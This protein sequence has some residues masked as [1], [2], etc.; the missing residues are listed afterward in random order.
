MGFSHVC[1]DQ[2]YSRVDTPQSVLELA[3]EHNRLNLSDH[4]VKLRLHRA[5][6]SKEVWDKPCNVLSG[7]ER[8]RLYLCCLMISDHVPDLFLLDEPTN[9]LDLQSLAILTATI[10][11]YRGTLLVISHDA[12]FVENIGVTREVGLEARR[13]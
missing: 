13:R 11:D 4:E 9:N 7:G 3:R 8:M 5:L 6:F 10:R 1:L 2:E 12:K